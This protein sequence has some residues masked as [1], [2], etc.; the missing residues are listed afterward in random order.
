MS[1]SLARIALLV[2]TWLLFTSCVH[3][4]VYVCVQGRLADDQPA[5]ACVPQG[6]AR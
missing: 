2:V 5:I 3:F 4:P 6:G 1:A